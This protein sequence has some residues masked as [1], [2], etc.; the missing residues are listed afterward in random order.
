MPAALLVLGAWALHGPPPPPSGSVDCLCI[1]PV[2]RVEDKN[3]ILTAA[4]FFRVQLE[5]TDA[6]FEAG[7]RPDLLLW[8]ETMWPFPGMEETGTGE[9]RRPWVDAP[10]EVHSI[11]TVRRRQRKMVQAVFDRSSNPVSRPPYFLTGAHFYYPVPEGAPPGVYS[12]RN[13]EFVLFDHDGTLVQHFSK[14]QLVPFGESLPFG[15]IFPGADA[16]TRWAHRSF[17][18]RPDFGRTERVGPLLEVGQLPRLGGAVCWENVFEQTFRSQADAGA[19]AFVILSNEDWFGHDGIEMEQMVAAT[20]LRALECGLAVL[21]ATNTGQT[22]LVSADG[23]VL[24]GPTPGEIT[25]WQVDLPVADAATSAT[26]YRRGAWMLLPLWS[27]CTVLFGL[28]GLLR[29]RRSEAGS[30]P[31]GD[32]C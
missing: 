7:A 32:P 10:D 23:E 30:Q 3:R 16:L 2:V 11:E 22:C 15:G 17:G 28:F 19:Q 13:T 9:M 1:Q 18:L 20:R 21:R 31:I 6:A 25:W 12:P 4:D 27:L 26:M 24:L 5:V 14:Q 8:S 29:R